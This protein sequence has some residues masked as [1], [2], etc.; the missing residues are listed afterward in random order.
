MVREWINARYGFI[1]ALIVILRYGLFSFWVNSYWGGAFTALGG[2]LL[3]GGFKAVKSR[4]NLLNGV[5]VGLGVII[6]MTTRPYEGM[7]FAVPFG[8]ALIVHF[9]RSTSLERRSLVPAGLAAAVLVA[10]R[11]GLTLAHNQAV[12]RDWKVPPYMLYSR[13]VGQA[14]AF[15]MESR[16]PQHEGQAR[17]A[18]TR[19]ALDEAAAFYDRK[20]TRAGISTAEALRLRNYWNFYVGFALLIPFVVGIYALRGEPTVLLA[21]GSLGLGLSLGS[22]DFAHYAAPGV[23]SRHIGDHGRIQEPAPMAAVGLSVWAVAQPGS[24]VGAGPRVNRSAGRP[25]D[26]R[27]T[28]PH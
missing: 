15:L 13:T 2:V 21:A 17:Y 25:A 7:L 23:W 5:A 14:P 11:F 24:A 26:R 27:R 20:E 9:I 22:Y 18:A 8:A 3:L 12:T 10:A 4:P 6:L 19:K 1:A 16:D 28:R